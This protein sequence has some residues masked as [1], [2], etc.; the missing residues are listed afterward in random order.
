MACRKR[1]RCYNRRPPSRDSGGGNNQNRGQNDSCGIFIGKFGFKHE[2][3]EY[4]GGT[5]ADSKN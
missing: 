5:H 1:G 3:S 4:P 2:R